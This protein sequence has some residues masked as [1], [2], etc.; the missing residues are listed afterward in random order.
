MSK[1]LYI[2]GLGGKRSILLQRTYIGVLN[3]FRRKN[4]HISFFDPHWETEEPYATKFERLRLHYQQAE[5]PQTVWAV[6]AGASLAVRLCVELDSQPKLNIVCGK[7]LGSEK[8][9]ENYR[10]RAPAFM[11]SVESS[12]ILYNDLDPDMTTCYIPKDDA[13]GVIETVDMTVPGSRIVDL[14]ALRHA[15]AIGYALLRYLPSS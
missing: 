8:I 12:E 13:D 14:P 4:N 7:V 10:R 6:S 3:V 15:R 1:S 9:G 2:P 11:E 5:T